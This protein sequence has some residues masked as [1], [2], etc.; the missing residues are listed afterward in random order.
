MLLN[1]TIKYAHREN[2]RMVNM[3]T[4]LPYHAHFSNT[5]HPLTSYEVHPRSARS[6]ALLL[7]TSM[8]AA[9]RKVRNTLAR[10]H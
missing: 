7:M 9:A 10:R 3:M 8:R 2:M 6:F 4:D 1:E 5:R